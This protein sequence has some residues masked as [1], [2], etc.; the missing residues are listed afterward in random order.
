MT[1]VPLPVTVLLDAA[2]AGFG[3]LEVRDSVVV[4]FSQGS[5]LQCNVNPTPVPLILYFSCFQLTSE[6]AHCLCLKEE[7][8]LR[9]GLQL[10]TERCNLMKP[11]FC[12]PPA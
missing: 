6:H 3:I 4:F 9:L 5:N 7:L 12:V 1:N 2:V 11:V 8:A 10:E